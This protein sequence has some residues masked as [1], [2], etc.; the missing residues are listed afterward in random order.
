MILW[1]LLFGLV[2]AISFVLAFKSMHDFQ[3]IPAEGGEEY[4]L[5]LI[6][7]LSQLNK[8]LLTSFH[9]E[10]STSTLF[11]SFERLIKGTKAALVV[12]GP[13]KI[14]AKYKQQLD[15]LE[16]EDYTNVRPEQFAAWEVVVKHAG[17]PGFPP[18]PAEDQI[19]WQLILSTK[20]GNFFHPHI[21]LAVVSNHPK[22]R[23][24][25]KAKLADL[26]PDKFV[27]LPNTF[28][29]TQLLDYYN[30]RG[31]RKDAHNKNLNPDDVIRLLDV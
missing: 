26:S 3:E 27:K 6:R 1:I 17:K 29:N 21:R 8:Q 10:L 24:I 15:L 5:F 18:V 16:L 2:V 23:D 22:R 12:Y 14:L 20:E 28:S 19:W 11:I 7:R 13:K 31:F 30:K 25:L 4:G 9:K